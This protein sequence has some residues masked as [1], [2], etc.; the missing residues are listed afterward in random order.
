MYINI[1]KKKLFSYYK[2]C[3]IRVV[4][5]IQKIKFAVRKNFQNS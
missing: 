4:L 2:C 1:P 5:N 3:F